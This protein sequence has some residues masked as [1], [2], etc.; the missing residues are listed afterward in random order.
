ME[1][2]RPSVVFL[3]SQPDTLWPENEEEIRFV[4][5]ERVNALGYP[6]KLLRQQQRFNTI[7]LVACTLLRLS[8]KP[9]LPANLT[10]RDI[11]VT[12]VRFQHSPLEIWDFFMGKP[13]L[14]WR[15]MEYR[16]CPSFAQ[17]AY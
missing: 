17:R 8:F 15:M 10:D 9:P 12:R 2:S 1:V 11:G 16:A 14:D 7:V 5:G 6:R 13:A 4:D 3:P